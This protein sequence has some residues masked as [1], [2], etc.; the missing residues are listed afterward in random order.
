M[1]PLTRLEELYEYPEGRVFSICV[2]YYFKFKS[3]YAC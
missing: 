1:G 3:H 2:I